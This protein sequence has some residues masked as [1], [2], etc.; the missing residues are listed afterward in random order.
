MSDFWHSSSCSVR[1]GRSVFVISFPQQHCTQFGT[2]TPSEIS[3]TVLHV[4]LTVLQ[5]TL[6]VLHATLTVYQVTLTV[7]QVT[8]TVLQ[9]C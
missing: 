8:L 5:V 7:Y 6:T 9:V 2:C 1:C 3:R 4:T